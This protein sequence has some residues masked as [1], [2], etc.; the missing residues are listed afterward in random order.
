MKI[1]ELLNIYYWGVFV[2]FWTAELENIY[3]YGI[4]N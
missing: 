3:T 4:S 2:C 1:I